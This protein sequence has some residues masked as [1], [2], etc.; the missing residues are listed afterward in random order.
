MTGPQ[1]NGMHVFTRRTSLLLMVA[2]YVVGVAI[3]LVY[4][5]GKHRSLEFEAV[6][7]D[8]Y[9]QFAAKAFDPSSTGRYAVN[10]EGRNIY[11]LADVEGQRGLHQT[12]HFEPVKYVYAAL[13]G[14]T[15]SPIA[16][17]IFI[18]VCY[19][20]PLLYLA[21]IATGASTR[22]NIFVLLVGLAYVLYPSTPRMVSFDLR[23]RIFV[24]PA[25]VV[26]ILAIIYAR[27]MSEKML[28]FILF[29]L[30]REEAV[31]LAPLLLALDYLRGRMNDQRTRVVPF[32]L[33][34]ATAVAAVVLYYRWTGYARDPVGNPWTSYVPEHAVAI[35]TVQFAPQ[36][37]VPSRVGRVVHD[38]LLAPDFTILF[39]IVLLG[40]LAA[41]RRIAPRPWTMRV[42]GLVVAACA[43]I[44]LVVG[45]RD[46]PRYR[47]AARQ[48]HPVF[49]LRRTTDRLRT[50]ILTDYKTSQAF[51]DYENLLVY[52]RLPWFAV[53]ARTERFYPHNAPLVRAA[54]STNVE[55]VVV[56]NSHLPAV[57]ALM[58]DARVESRTV[59]QNRDYTIL[60]IR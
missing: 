3:G 47:T 6:D 1:A 29:L 12:L 28:W 10:P 30:A 13:Y 31:V 15:G 37:S 5:V 48:A 34:W 59:R 24:I 60:R 44:Q 21:L 11:G 23:P 8:F 33:I 58:T 46:L 14:W 52:E 51:N 49:D 17:F 45:L 25:L 43:A 54:L 26:L 27:P 36:E 22:E 41:R 39:V 55:Y 42:L 50:A 35:W 57:T 20:A 7:F 38:I 32:V 4:N 2:L 18:A 16:L 40:L 56:R 9:M 53:G 19:F